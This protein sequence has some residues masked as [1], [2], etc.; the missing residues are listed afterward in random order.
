MSRVFANGSGHRVLVQGQVIPKTQKWFLTPPCITL[1]T[2]SYLTF[3]H[4]LGTSGG[5]MV[6]KVD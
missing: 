5:V 4:E 1:S 3:T 6:S 2:I